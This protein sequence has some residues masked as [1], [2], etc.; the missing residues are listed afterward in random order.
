MSRILC[1]W[2]LGD[3]L[4]H[5]GRFSPFISELLKRGHEIN[6]VVSNLSKTQSFAWDSRVKFFQAPLN[7]FKLSSPPR[8]FCFADILLITQKAT[9][10]GRGHHDRHRLS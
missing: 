3:D 5:L 7:F 4:G 6:F 2:E 10:C 1:V 9:S 8:T